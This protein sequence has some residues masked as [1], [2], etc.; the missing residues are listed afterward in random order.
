MKLL[1]VFIVLFAILT[2]VLAAPIVRINGAVTSVPGLER[3]V[4]PPRWVKVANRLLTP[5]I[6]KRENYFTMLVKKLKPSN[7]HISESPVSKSAASKLPTSWLK[8]IASKLRGWWQKLSGRPTRTSTT[9][10][11]ETSELD[12]NIE[13]WSDINLD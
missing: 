13:H 11:S 2:S 5:A 9:S 6:V 8:E 1:N 3:T 4:L 10:G 12:P 7:V